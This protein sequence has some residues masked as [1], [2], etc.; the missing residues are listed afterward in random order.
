VAVVAAF[1][2]GSAL[3]GGGWGYWLGAGA[4]AVVA[5]VLVVHVFL[6]TTLLKVRTRTGYEPVL[7]LETALDDAEVASLND[8]L[9]REL[10]WPVG[11]ATRR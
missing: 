9:A 3:D 8:R 7:D 2:A 10:R 4:G 1:L 11:C 5:I 6:P